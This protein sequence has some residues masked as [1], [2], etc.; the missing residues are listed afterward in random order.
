MK[1]LWSGPFHYA[2][3][4]SSVNRNMVM[5]LKA[6]GV[7]VGIVPADL[8]GMHH[9]VDMYAMTRDLLDGFKRVGEGGPAGR[10]CVWTGAPGAAHKSEKGA[11]YTTW[12]TAPLSAE[13]ADRLK[14][15]RRV[16]VPSRFCREAF[17]AS[18]LK[19]E[20][21]R[22]VP[23]GVNLKVFD[24]LRTPVHRPRYLP[25]S[26]Y[27]FAFSGTVC[28]RKNWGTLL[29][30]F[31][32]EFRPGEDA[33]LLMFVTGS[34]AGRA[35]A[36][37]GKEAL[38]RPGLLT[39][40]GAVVFSWSPF[41]AVEALPPGLSDTEYAT[42]M[43]VADCW[44]SVT[45]GEGYGL[46]ALEALALGKPV[47]SPKWGGVTEFLT[48]EN[49]RFVPHEEVPLNGKAAYVMCDVR[50]QD[51]GAAMREEYRLGRR[52]NTAGYETARSFSYDT[53][54]AGRVMEELE[55]LT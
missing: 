49:A 43:N 10:R 39:T 3:S 18:G 55:D 20:R 32:G 6:A 38:R 25:G 47:I 41:A 44:V 21:V 7:D 35:A 33:A 31:L 22:V 11:Y 42:R 45:H 50:A 29:N 51:V 15:W 40:D 26:P 54:A 14:R 27:A 12:E 1:V 37:I 8:V 46:T 16:W 34:Q 53:I 36:L 17:L 24:A 48:E 13:Y 23:H 28:P 19:E 5:A 9:P 4:F 30:A 52:R 2:D